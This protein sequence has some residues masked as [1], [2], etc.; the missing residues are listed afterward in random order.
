M[1][2]SMRNAVSNQTERYATETA[3]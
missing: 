2:P 3:I 1:L